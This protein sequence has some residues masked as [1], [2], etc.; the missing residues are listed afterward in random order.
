MAG[1]DPHG[2]DLAAL[3]AY[4]RDEAPGLLAGPL[5]GRLVAGGRSNLTY[6]VTDGVGTWVVRRPPLGHVLET[7]H[8][9]G[10]EHRVMAGLRG[11][12]VPVPE[13]IAL[14]RDPEV[15]GA[16]FY[17]MS[18][19]AGTVYR[20]RDQLAEVSPSGA[21]E[22]A[23]GLV[24]VLANLHAVDTQAAGL[25]DLG[26]PAGYLERQVRRW[27]KQL[28]ASHSREVPDLASLGRRLAE[29]VPVSRRMALVHG[30]YKLDNVVVDPADHG[31]VL[32]VLDWEMA[33]LGDPL[34]DLVNVVLWW[35]GVRDTEGVPFAAV[36]AEVPGFPSSTHLLDRYATASGDDLQGL[37][38]YMGLACYKLA[39]IFEGMYYRDTQGLTVG[40]GFD[41][42][43]S[44]PPALARRGH[45]VLDRGPHAG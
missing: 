22:L 40:E 4:L 9:M 17:V 43:A 36:P 12:Q 2:L 44:L 33:T 30:D 20:T 23:D 6:L 45:E 27:G 16:P 24:D 29:S 38:W 18:F 1:G 19:V 42:L 21:R 14:C 26:R 37:P 34:T 8:D 11:S 31:R 25:A 15:I 35:D 5:S 41:R 7:A 39:A 3:T 10:R 28:D 13:M 32:A